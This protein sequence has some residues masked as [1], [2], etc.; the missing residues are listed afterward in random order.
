MIHH[1]IYID[2]YIPHNYNRVQYKIYRTR[3]QRITILYTVLYWKNWSNI[4]INYN[5]YIKRWV[6]FLEVVYQPFRVAK[7]ESQFGLLREYTWCCILAVEAEATQHTVCTA[8]NTE[9][10]SWIQDHYPSNLIRKIGTSH[11]NKINQTCLPLPCRE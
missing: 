8:P 2:W 6:G 9:Q 5:I 7:M 4:R 11:K 10:S 1:G 3:H